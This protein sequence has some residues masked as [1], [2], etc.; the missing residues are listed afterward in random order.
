MVKTLWGC[1]HMPIHNCTWYLSTLYE[2]HGCGMQSEVV[3]SLNLGMVVTWIT[4]NFS[5]LLKSCCIIYGGNGVRVHSHAHPQLQQ[6]II[7][8]AYVWHGCGMQFERSYSLHHSA[9]ASFA[10]IHRQ[11]FQ[12]AKKNCEVASKIWQS[13]TAEGVKSPYICVTWMWDALWSGFQPQP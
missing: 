9:V 1:I 12:S 13:T 4:Y 2:W 8:L 11:Q 10:L 7:H 3:Y 5:Q 6:V